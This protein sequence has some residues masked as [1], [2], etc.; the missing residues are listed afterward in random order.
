[1][2]ACQADPDDVYPAE[3][4]EEGCCVVHWPEALAEHEWMRGLPSCA[5]TGRLADGDVHDLRTAG[6]GHLVAD[7]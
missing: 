5:V 4:G 2:S 1:M 7:R 6:R 3:C